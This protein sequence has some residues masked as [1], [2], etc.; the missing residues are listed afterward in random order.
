MVGTG[1][2]ICVRPQ[3]LAKIDAHLKHFKDMVRFG[4]DLDLKNRTLREVYVEGV[5][6]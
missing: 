6:S 1:A 3:V 4:M 5:D 2:T